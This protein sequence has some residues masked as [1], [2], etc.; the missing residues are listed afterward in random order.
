M[1]H[2]LDKQG[3]IN[4]YDIE[5]PDGS[6]ET[7]VPARLLEKVKDSDDINEVHES[8]GIQKEDQSVSERRYKK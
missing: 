7:N 5:W 2:S 6:I 4:V 1:W 8:H 3:N